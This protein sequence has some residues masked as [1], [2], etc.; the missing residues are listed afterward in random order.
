MAQTGS[1]QRRRGTWAIWLAGAMVVLSLAWGVETVL[2]LTFI[3]A[4]AAAGVFLSRYIPKTIV[5]PVIFLVMMAPFA[6]FVFSGKG[7][8]M[9]PL[10]LYPFA[11]PWCLVPFSEYPPGLELRLLMIGCTIN[12]ILVGVAGF[13]LDRRVGRR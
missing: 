1:T 2:V 13:L 5:L 8:H 9:T 10:M 4:C 6:S 3:G 7:G 11:I 12:T